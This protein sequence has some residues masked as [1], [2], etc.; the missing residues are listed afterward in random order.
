MT[1]L[2]ARFERWWLRPAPALR[3]ALVRILVGAYAIGL[4]AVRGSHYAAVGQLPASRFQPLGLGRLLDTPLPGALSTAL[5]VLAGALAIAFTLGWR[6][7]VTGPAFALT[8]L[9]IATYRNCFGHAAH[10]DNLVALHLVILAVTPAADA[11]SLDARRGPRAPPWHARYAWP[12]RLMAVVTALTYVLA[13][14]AKLR[15]GGLEWL[16][17]DAV[18][19]QV[20][21]DALR[22]ARLGEAPAGLA[23]WSLAHPSIFASFA[24]ATLTLELGAPL[25][26][27]SRKLAVV[28]TAGLWGMHIG[29]AAIMWIAFPYPLSLIAF[30]PL[31]RLERAA[32]LVRRRWRRRG[33]SARPR[34]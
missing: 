14:M 19:L 8:F 24:V 25:A 9:W 5:V 18:R 13:G 7:R 16:G 31:F 29:V 4:L 26:L 23:I 34:L 28:W 17:G 2:P 27:A 21:Y 32:A 1:G 3:P 10:L 30:A 33:R 20:A 22:K 11:M 6:Y 12:L 15:F